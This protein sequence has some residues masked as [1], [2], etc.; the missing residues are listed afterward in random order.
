MRA[1]RD[2]FQA[3]LGG[4]VEEVVVGA[5]PCGELRFP[6]YPEANGWR[7]PGVR[8]PARGSAA[9]RLAR[10][11]AGADGSARAPGAC[12]ALRAHLRPAP[13]CKRRCGVACSAE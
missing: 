8:C 7:F 3:E 9:P 1:F 5:G 2:A 13:R 10:C 12:R 6:S 4:L 11:D